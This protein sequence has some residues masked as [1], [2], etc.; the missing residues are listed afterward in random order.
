MFDV[1][2][3]RWV[4]RPTCEHPMFWEVHEGDVYKGTWDNNLPHGQGLL[5]FLKRGSY[6]GTFSRGAMTGR[7]TH[8]TGRW[9]NYRREY[10]REFLDGHF[11]GHG[12][13]KFSLCV[14]QDLRCTDHQDVWD[15]YKGNF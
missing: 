11:H 9:G 3:G 7:G 14:D 1:V 10:V 2:E 15:V 4:D 8:W 13:L 6:E 12:T 5:T